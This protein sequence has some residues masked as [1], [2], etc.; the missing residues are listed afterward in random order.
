MFRAEQG[1]KEGRALFHSGMGLKDNQ[2]GF[3]EEAAPPYHVTCVEKP[4][5]Q[6]AMT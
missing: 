2:K 5:Q 3:I 4:F 6:E 1:H